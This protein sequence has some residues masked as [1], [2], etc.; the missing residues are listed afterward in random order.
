MFLYFLWH[1]FLPISFYKRCFI[2]VH[3]FYMPQ[4]CVLEC[5]DGIAGKNYKFWKLRCN[6]HACVIQWAQCMV[7]GSMVVGNY[8]IIPT[9]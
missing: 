8:L 5:V 9:Y 3:N 4:S 1:P 6:I 2:F 7:T